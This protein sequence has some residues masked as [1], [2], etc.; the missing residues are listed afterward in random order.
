MPLQLTTAFHK[1]KALKKKIRIIQGG[2]GAS[3][4][5]SI[6]QLF[7]LNTLKEKITPDIYTIVT[8]TYPQ[9]RDGAIADM[10]NICRDM[11]LDF[12]QFYIKSE[13]NFNIYGD[14]IQFRHL[15]NK[16]FHK[17]KGARRSYLFI[18]EAN[19]T[20]YTSIEQMLVRTNKGVFI[21]YNPDKE[22]WAHDMMKTG[23]NDIDFITLTYLDNEC[24]SEGEKQEIEMRK[25][26]AEKPDAS[27]AIKLW[28]QVYGLGQVGVYSERQIYSYQFTDEIPATAKR[29]PSGED[30][31]FSPDPTTH[32]D[33]WLDGINLYADEV[34]TEC[35]LEPVK[36][37]GLEK[38]AVVDKLDEIKH[39]KGWLIIGDSEAARTIQDIQKHGYNIRGVKKNIAVIEGIKLVRSYN[40][41]ITKRSTGIK[42][43]C[44]SWFFKVDDNGKIIHEPDGHEPDQLAAIR[45]VMMMKGKL[46]N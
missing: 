15:D 38:Y 43:A 25:A 30:Y 28:W 12:D 13:S 37:P 7:L 21:D 18:N 42:K 5:Y 27:A 24:I 40:L 36:L 11:G 32:I 45:Y 10:K 23:R 29:L 34:F 16:D 2:Q 8:E 1:I 4:T 35:N 20:S 31:G 44:E 39:L 33:L 26:E 19:R 46:W 6:L 14:Q 22:F 41:F 17:A 3:K 9:L